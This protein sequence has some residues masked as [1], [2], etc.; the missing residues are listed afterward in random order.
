MLDL[1][2]IILIFILDSMPVIITKGIIIMPYMAFLSY[3]KTK[4]MLFLFPVL[5]IILSMYTINPI[6]SFI[7]IGLNLV[8]YFFYF[9][10][11][12]YNAFNIYLL[13]ILQILSW[14]FFIREQIDIK[15]ILFLSIFYY[16]I[17]L[18]YLRRVIE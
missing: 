7:F 1:I 5:G 18:F 9:S 10:N 6:T 12:E 13:S 11:F 16:L 17:N 4:R 14:K 15:E 2:S 8:F 3:R